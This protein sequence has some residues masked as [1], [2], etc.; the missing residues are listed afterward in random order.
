MPRL[1]KFISLAIAG[2][3]DWILEKKP[4]KRL[5]KKMSWF[6][7]YLLAIGI[8][9]LALYIAMRLHVDVNLSCFIWNLDA[10][11][12]PSP[13]ISRDGAD[14]SSWL[15]TLLAV[16]LNVGCLHMWLQTTMDT[17]VHE[18]KVILAT[19]QVILAQ[20][21][22]VREI[23]TASCIENWKQRVH[24]TPRQQQHNVQ[25]LCKHILFKAVYS[26]LHLLVIAIL[27]I[28]AFTY[29]IAQSVGSYGVFQLF[30]NSTLVS[31]WGILLKS[32][33]YQTATMLARF[34]KRWD[35]DAHGMS[36]SSTGIRFNQWRTK[37]MFIILWAADIVVPL[38]SIL[39]FDESCLRYYLK[40]SPSIR[41]VAT[42]S[43]TAQWPL[44]TAH[45]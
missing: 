14:I 25:R 36:D 13:Y 6:S 3:T 15:L 30:S 10:T 45:Y 38:S 29:M 26:L 37:S 44:L 33:L 28:P 43:H 1:S 34:R 4:R 39:L 19:L 7:T 16:V 27:S 21:C 35:P 22:A 5:L 24:S 23:S 31:I 11:S 2:S 8:A 18:S 9:T 41:G 42:H 20:C 17:Q 40:F 12:L 32:Y